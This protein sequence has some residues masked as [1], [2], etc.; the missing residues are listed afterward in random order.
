[1]TNSFYVIRRFIPAGAGH[2]VEDLAETDEDQALYAANFWADIS[3]GV[4]VLRPDGT[5]LREIG[6]V[7]M[8]L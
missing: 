8:M 6:D 5:V 2:T 4:R 1:M 7:P 3:I